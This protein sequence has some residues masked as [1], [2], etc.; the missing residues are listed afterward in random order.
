MVKNP[1]Q[2][3]S[4]EDIIKFLDSKVSKTKRLTGG[5]RFIDAIPKN[6]VRYFYITRLHYTL[7]N[8]VYIVGENSTKRTARYGCCRGNQ[9]IEI[10]TEKEKAYFMTMAVSCHIDISIDITKIH[11]YLHILS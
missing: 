2:D 8:I 9:D 1:G 11:T 3:V 10:I 4:A 6:P 7:A 5:V